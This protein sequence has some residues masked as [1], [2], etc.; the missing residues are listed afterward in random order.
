MYNFDIEKPASI[1]EAVAALGAEDAQ[2]LGGGQTLIP[3]LKARLASPSKL[4][5]LAGVA[6]MQGIT[7]NGG[8]LRIGGATTHGKVAADGNYPALSALAAKIGDPAVRNRGT[9]GGSLANNDPA[10]CYP[11]AALASGATIVTNSREIPADDFFVG[12]FE[13]A[14]EEGEI[15][16]AVEF[17]IPQAANYQKFAQPASRFPLVGVFVAKTDSTV[18]VAVTG[19]SNNGVFRWT[20][21]EDALSGNFAASAID[22][23][24]VP[25]DDMIS[26]L[27]GSAAYR[28]HLIKV[29][30]GRAVTAST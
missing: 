30:T 28:A 27:H 14:L 4:V 8:V 26:D 10:A 11:A 6:E 13:T 29:M 21:A 16:T 1:A 25:A 5:S 12:M 15:V 3:T 23:L 22:G 18:R 7:R 20:E 19:A 9:I 17:P 2:A 24:T